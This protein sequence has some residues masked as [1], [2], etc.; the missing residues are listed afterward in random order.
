M[1]KLRSKVPTN[2]ACLFET[3]ETSPFRIFIIRKF[4]AFKAKSRIYL[5]LI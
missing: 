4:L 3:Y 2:F 1:K 5:Y